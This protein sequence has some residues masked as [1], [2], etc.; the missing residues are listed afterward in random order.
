MCAQTGLWAGPP[1]SIL[2]I[3]TE[4][5]Y[6][7]LF[8][9]FLRSHRFSLFFPYLLQTTDCL[10]VPKP[11]RLSAFGPALSPAQEWADTA[12]AASAVLD[13]SS[14]FF[15]FFLRNFDD[16][17]A[18]WFLLQFEVGFVSVNKLPIGGSFRGNLFEL[19]AKPDWISQSN[20]DSFFIPIVKHVV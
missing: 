6:P 10:L 15:F 19:C 14:A 17:S 4:V 13:I 11:Q 12:V 18:F 1:K 9:L 3:A 2:I 16:P 7:F 8:L 5:H 20:Q